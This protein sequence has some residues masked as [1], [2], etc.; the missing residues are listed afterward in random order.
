MRVVVNF[1]FVGQRHSTCDIDGQTVARIN[2]GL[3]VSVQGSFLL[4]LSFW[5]SLFLTPS[6]SFIH[7]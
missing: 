7:L 3:D 2:E 5:A 1:A 4:H 6:F